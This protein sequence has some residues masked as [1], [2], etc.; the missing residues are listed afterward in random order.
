MHLPHSIDIAAVNIC[1]GASAHPFTNL[2]VNITNRKFI[3]G[4]KVFILHRN[5]NAFIKD[6]IMSPVEY[7]HATVAALA[8][9]VRIAMLLPRQPKTQQQLA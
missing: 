2:I 4:L 3:Y 8:V 9:I 6:K 5:I 7:F 1:A